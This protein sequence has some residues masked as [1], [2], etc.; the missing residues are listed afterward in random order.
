M[1]ED[2]RSLSPN[3]FVEVSPPFVTEAR[4]ELVFTEQ[5]E[6]GYAAALNPDALPDLLTD[7]GLF[8]DDQ[9]AALFGLLSELLSACRRFG[10][11]AAK[12][13]EYAARDR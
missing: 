2:I 1:L 9:R 11:G 12:E 10:D 13:G 6:S 8:R 5:A 4:P 7:D 3:P